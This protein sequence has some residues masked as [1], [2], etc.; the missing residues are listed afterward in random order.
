MH[1]L[2][3]KVYQWMKIIVVSY[4]PLVRHNSQHFK[5]RAHFFKMIT[6]KWAFDT[7]KAAR[8]KLRLVAIQLTVN[9]RARYLKVSKLW[10]VVS[11]NLRPKLKIGKCSVIRRPPRYPHI[12]FQRNRNMFSIWK[13]VPT[14]KFW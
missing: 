5:C 3:L 8:V 14:E 6:W 2:K 12:K 7:F 9:A 13:V 11:Q 4:S 10:V 1:R